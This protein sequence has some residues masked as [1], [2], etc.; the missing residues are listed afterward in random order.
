MASVSSITRFHLSLLFAFALLLDFAHVS[1]GSPRKSGFSPVL[2]LFNLKEKSKFWTESIMHGD[3]DDLESSNPTKKGALNYSQAGNIANYLKLKEVDSL[4]LPVPVNFIFIGFEGKGNQDFRLQAEELERWFTNIDHIFEHTRIPQIEEVRNPFH[5]INVDK[6]NHHFPTLSHVN[7][8]FS[9]HAIQMN[10]KVTSLFEQAIAV[11]SRKEDV[12]LTGESNN[13]LW[14]VD[15]DMME[16]IFESLVEYLQL[17]NAYNIFVLNPKHNANMTRYGYRQNK[18]L[19]A[20]VRESNGVSDITL[21]IEKIQRPLYEKHPMAK[22]SWTATEETDTVEW[23]SRCSEALNSIQSLYQGKDT[24]YVVQSKVLQVAPLKVLSGKSGDLKL[25]LQKD[26]KSGDFNSLHAECL[27]DTWIGKDRWAFVDLSAGPFTWGPAVGGQ[28]VRTEQSLP[29]VTKTIGAV[30]EITEEEAEEHLQNAIQEK[31]SALG[32]KEHEAIDIL[33]AEIDI[34]ELFAFKHCKGRKVRLALCEELDERMKELKNELQ[35]MDGDEFSESHKRKALDALNKM[36]RWNLFSDAQVKMHNYTVARDSFLAHLEIQEHQAIT[37]GSKGIN[38]G[39]II[40]IITFP[41]SE[42]Q[43]AHRNLEE[44]LR[45]ET[46]DGDVESIFAVVLNSNGDPFLIRQA[47]YFIVLFECSRH[48]ARPRVTG[49]AQR[50]CESRI[51][52]S[53]AY[54]FAIIR[55]SL[56]LSDDPALAM[57]FSVSRRAAAVPMLLVNGTY[58]KL[59]SNYLDSS[60]LQH[61]LQR[62]NDHNSLKGKHANDRLTLEVP[63][64]WF[65]HGDPLLVD[66]HYQ[67]KALSDMIIVV[68][69]DSSSWE[70][71]LQCNGNSILWDLRKPIKA[72]IAAASEHLAGLLPLHLVYSHAHETA[73]ELFGLEHENIKLQQQPLPQNPQPKVHYHSGTTC[74]PSPSISSYPVASVASS[75][76]QTT[77]VGSL[78]PPISIIPPLSKPFQWFDEFRRGWSGV[79]GRR[80]GAGGRWRQWQSGGAS[81]AFGRLGAGDRGEGVAGGCGEGSDGWWWMLASDRCGWLGRGMGYLGELGE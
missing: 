13:D 11:L 73:M 75:P 46:C 71:H 65:I 80:V 31:F 67:A 41:E 22:F 18:S 62:I 7:Y 8:N 23:S 74:Y 48:S 44:R 47:S 16:V 43:S 76:S 60:I 6:G 5:N 24:D 17:G 26:L 77:L 59:V 68:Q 58:R 51:H 1:H 19:Q 79:F 14:Q 72:A 42:V 52:I 56:P 35:S 9:V 39:A 66:K 78:R 15:M 64:F 49:F 54:Q 81:G 37:S 10:E 34:Y 57:A 21:A 70:S 3:F 25:A 33:L 55:E 63:I 40:F 28:G 38:G 2:S 20:S 4:Y 61:Q 12:S 29:N 50:S 30:S 32:D 27:T 45:K 69:S 53:Y 36:E